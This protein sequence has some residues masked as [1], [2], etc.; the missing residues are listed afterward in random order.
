M[1]RSRGVCAHRWDGCSSA[2]P[3]AGAAPLGCSTSHLQVSG[4]ILLMPQSL[5]RPRSHDLSE[6]TRETAQLLW[7]HPWVHNPA[8]FNH[9]AGAHWPTP[10]RIPI[11][12]HSPRRGGTHRA[13]AVC[14]VK[15]WADISSCSAVHG[16]RAKIGAGMYA[17]AAIWKGHSQIKPCNPDEIWAK[18]SFT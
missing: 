16:S 13:H 17:Q 1:Q 5:H 12:A 7:N 4:Q 15:L 9:G 3:S 10:Q 2:D 14:F 18:D 11:H 6:T 8:C